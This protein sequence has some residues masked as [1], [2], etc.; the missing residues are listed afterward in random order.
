[1]VAPIPNRRGAIRA[2]PTKER[3]M[4]DLSRRSLLLGTAGGLA[5]AALGSSFRPAT[6]ARA[7]RA[8]A[9]RAIFAAGTTL[10]AVAT[11]AGTAGY[12]RLDAGAGYPLVVREEL[13]SGKPGRD[14]SRKALS[15]I[16]QFTDL[17]LVDAQSPM[18]FEHIVEIDSSAFRPHEALGTHA[19]SQLVERVNRLGVGPFTGRPFDCV[20]TTGDNSDNSETI[21]MQ[22]FLQV[23][24]GG[25]ITAN[26]G[27]DDRWEGVQ[28][29]GDALYYNPED[30]A[31]DRYKQAGFP[32]LDDY[33]RRVMAPHES[34][35]LHTPWYSVF[36]NHDDS[37]GG[38]V[39]AE[40]LPMEEL[41]TGTTKFIGFVED[42]AN[43]AVASAFQQGRP[44][45]LGEAVKPKATWQV[46]ADERRAPFSPR[47]F[48][49][50][51]L[52]GSATGPGPVG[53]GFDDEA[54]STG[55]AYYRFPIAPGV[56]GIALDSTNRAGF[57]H[58]SLG[59]EQFR[60]LEST[61]RAG[62]ST[63]FDATG[64]AV[65]SRRPD[66]YF[67]LFSHHTTGTMD[68]SLPDPSRPGEARHLGP[69]IVE[70]VQRFPNVLAWVNGHT[71]SNS[72]TPRRGPSPER[73]F[74]EINTASHIEFPQQARIIDVC[75]NG[76]G[77]LSLFTTLIES[78]AP[79]QASYGDGSQAALASLYREF[80]LNDLYYNPSHEGTP[81]DHNTELLLADPLA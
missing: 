14:D 20:V 78:A 71:H 76:D 21:E 38:T 42:A 22:W 74:W 62:S 69:E 58:G 77:T 4:P 41:Y 66:S 8:P 54:A 39:P 12:R 23:M 47:D 73:G 57:T 19:A 24:N 29:S 60:W 63:Y 48:I 46:T 26:T 17:H 81:L 44:S 6:P 33:F 43:A 80:S 37:V 30:A 61:L 56:T 70:L 51:H 27:A 67:V 35:G 68:N 50:A 5:L 9:S 75:S 52:E 15:S 2:E 18:R 16:V 79:Y 31:P 40:W 1:M 32:G 64:A 13:C 59:D 34:P 65:H 7:S 10:E 36:G 49:A 72:I 3:I 45:G 25:T 28:T 55:N 11:A 53:H